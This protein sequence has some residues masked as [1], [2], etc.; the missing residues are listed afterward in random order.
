MAEQLGLF[1][2]I[3]ASAPLRPAGP[4]VD[5]KQWC[6]TTDGKLHQPPPGSF[7]ME[8]YQAAKLV[9]VDAPAPPAFACPY[10]LSADAQ[11]LADGAC[12]ACGEV[13]HVTCPRSGG[14][15]C[16]DAQRHGCPSAVVCEALGR[17]VHHA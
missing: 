17:E 16:E 1:G 9:Q 8:P 10:C 3:A 12:S 7:G 6:W 13:I 4:V 2:A 14:A 11:R 15:L 5:G